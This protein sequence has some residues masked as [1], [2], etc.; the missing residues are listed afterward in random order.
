M[1]RMLW[2][3]EVGETARRNIW[4]GMVDGWRR[5]WM[6]I[7]MRLPIRLRLRYRMRI[8]VIHYCSK[9]ASIS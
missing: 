1:G 5:M 3:A 4:W 6:R 2:W 9:D 7:G 8:D